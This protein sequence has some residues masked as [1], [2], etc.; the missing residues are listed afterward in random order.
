ML[1]ASFLLISLSLVGSALSKVVKRDLIVANAQS[2]PDG[3]PRVAALVNGQFPA[4]VI[5]AQKGDILS[6]NVKNRLTDPTI[7]R[8][9]S[10][11]WHGL[12][13]HRTAAND[14]P[15]FVT[16]CPIAPGH[17]FLYQFPLNDQ[18]GTYWYHS[19][20]STQYCD[21][22]RGP[23]IIYDPDDPLKYLYD[24]DDESTVITL[25]D[26]YHTP[27]PALTQTFI[28]VTHAVPTPDSGLING[29][30]RFIG[31][32]AVPFSI[33]NVQAGKR[34][35]LRVINIG[36]RPFH[37]FSI[38]GHK[39]TIIVLHEP[40][41][42]DEFD[43]FAAQRYSAIL[44]ADQP[45]GNYWIRAPLT[46]GTPA[47]QPNG[48]PNL[49]VTLIKAI[50]RYAGAPNEEPTTPV[51]NATNPLVEQNLHALINP[52]AP[53]GSDPA[54]VPLTLQISVPNAPFFAI[55][56]VTFQPPS[57]PVLL[58]ILSGASQPT[59]F[60]PSENVILLPRNKTI[61]ISIPGGGAH[62]FHLHGH[63]F[64]VIRTSGSNV[65]NFV[66]PPRRDVVAV[67]GGNMTFR[68]RTDNPGMFSTCHIDWHLEV[69][70]AV[71]MG[72][73]VQDAVEGP[74][75]QIIPPAWDKLCPI[76]NAFCAIRPSF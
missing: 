69:G 36:C 28:N 4:P 53:G 14:G 35:R 30:G 76:Y 43:I 68:F 6:L 31:G 49:D 18:A 20:L 57:M 72:E 38:D 9:T 71:V 25:A 10:I 5:T 51:V 56:G 59:D 22:I 7:R 16:Q 19:H 39:L 23:L 33:V 42:V 45:V 47:N 11:H 65:T 1:P 46:G 15:A 2:A 32:P 60:L 44:H 37:S 52:G 8:S 29:A 73:A 27:A 3:F 62:P 41:E 24:V 54:D 67:N 48:N 63:V 75:S 58:Q 64:D 50:L 55:N 70:L 21:G 26:W 13:Q 40:L 34:Y 74:Q 61:E 17:D 66:N 12:F